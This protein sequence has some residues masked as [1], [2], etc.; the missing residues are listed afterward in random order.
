MSTEVILDSDTPS[1][2]QIVTMY[3]AVETTDDRGGRGEIIG[4]FRTQEEAKT[5]A[6]GRGWYGG[7]ADVSPVNLLIMPDG[8]AFV[9]RSR[10]P[11][12]IG[13]DLIAE[14]KRLR[15]SALARL[16]L[17]LAGMSPEE[18]AAIK[19]DADKLE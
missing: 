7:P 17:A 19:L 9:L 1:G 4:V 18:R 3:E 12:V 6:E 2:P 14:R 5:K 15:E 13:I 16:K 8:T 11:V 10:I